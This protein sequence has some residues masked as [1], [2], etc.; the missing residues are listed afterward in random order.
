MLEAFEPSGKRKLSP[1]DTC[2]SISQ[3]ERAGCCVYGCTHSEAI[4]PPLWTCRACHWQGGGQSVFTRQTILG[5]LINYY[6]VVLPAFCSARSVG[7]F[8]DRCSE[9][10]HTK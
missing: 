9:P 3:W 1:P 5:S 8:L 4:R 10:R 2:C 7:S 6:T